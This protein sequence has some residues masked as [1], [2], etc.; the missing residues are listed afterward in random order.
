MVENCGKESIKLMRAINLFTYTR[1]QQD[2]STEYSNILSQREKREK[3]KEH[4]FDALRK[5]VELLRN[6]N[7]EI[8]VFEGFFYSFKIEQIGKEFDLLKID[9]GN[10]VLNIELKS[11]QIEEEKIKKQL[12]QNKY[13]LNYLANDI[14]LFTF[15]GETQ[16]VYQYVDGS[17][18]KSSID[19]LLNVMR[20]FVAYESEG[21][22]TLFKANQYLISPINTPEV[23]LQGQ[24]FL[25]K[26]QEN[27]KQNI[28]DIVYKDNEATFFL[29]ITGK[30][31]TGKT[32]LLYDIARTVAESNNRCCVV[33][34]GILSEGHCYLNNHWS[35]VSV[36]A[37]KDLKGDGSNILLNYDFILVDESQR[38]YVS[39]VDAIKKIALENGKVVIFSYDFGQALSHAEEERDIPSV[40][41]QIEGFQEFSLSEKIRT[42][43]EIASFYKTLLD[44]NDRA[45]AYMNYSNIEILYANHVVEALELIDL[46][47]KKYGYVFI[48]YTQS[49]YIKS[50]IDIYP[51]KHDT[52]HVIGQEYDKV[53]IIV[54]EN[55]RYNESGKI[56]GKKHPNPDYLFYKLLYQGVSRAREKLCILVVNNYKMFKQISDIKYHMLENYQYNDNTNSVISAKTLNKMDKVIKD[57]IMGL[58]TYDAET[59][60]DAVNMIKEELLERKPRR[61]VIRSGIKLLNIVAI[62]NADDES[63]AQCVQQFID[64]VSQYA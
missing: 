44:L 21:V 50:V 40:L 4:E 33:H 6:K 26:Q 5:F 10:L 38:I 55:F 54:D 62:K 9:K 48:A 58:K 20:L 2:Y 51:N 1:I 29:G 43:K 14:K 17:I 41:R 52:H 15:V 30:A 64:Y 28:L 34:S 60:S 36:I 59:I 35:D 19:I 16:E 25:T 49:V 11:E 63:I 12:K 27:I 45:R 23:F 7:V 56:E 37:A 22:E 39:A 8:E 3:V 47:E 18:I 57:T 32:L 46:Y 53:M 13:Y 61:N 42:S 24:Y 31:G